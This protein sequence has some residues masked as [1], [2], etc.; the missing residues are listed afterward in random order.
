[1]KLKRSGRAERW[2]PIGWVMHSGTLA[3]QPPPAPAT[4][5]RAPPSLPPS[6]LHPR[7]GQGG[8]LEQPLVAHKGALNGRGRGGFLIR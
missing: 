7:Q 6:Q 3:R 5:G 8:G 2:S 4:G 1:M